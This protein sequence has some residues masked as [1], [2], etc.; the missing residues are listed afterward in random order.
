MSYDFFLAISLESAIFIWRQKSWQ[1]THMWP[2]MRVPSDL[3]RHTIY[4][5]ESKLCDL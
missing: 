1:A 5:K 4:V 3:S 2:V